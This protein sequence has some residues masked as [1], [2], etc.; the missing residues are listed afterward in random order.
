MDTVGEFPSAVDGPGSGEVGRRGKRKS[1]A[2]DHL[3]EFTRNIHRNHPWGLLAFGSPIT[4]V[5]GRSRQ[6]AGQSRPAVQGAD[7]T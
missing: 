6:R 2:S 3:G 7:M 5:I 4:N 1:A